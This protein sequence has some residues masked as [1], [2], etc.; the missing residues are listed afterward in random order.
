MAPQATALTKQPC[1]RIAT[2][3]TAASAANTRMCP[4]WRSK[5]GATRVPSTYP[6]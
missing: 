3:A 5:E 4:T 1:I 2:E 6:A